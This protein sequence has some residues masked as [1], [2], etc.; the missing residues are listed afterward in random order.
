MYAMNTFG[1]FSVVLA[2]ALFLP[3]GEF[4]TLSHHPSHQYTKWLSSCYLPKCYNIRY[5]THRYT[6]RALRWRPTT[7][8]NRRQKEEGTGTQ[9]KRRWENREKAK[10]DRGESKKNA[11]N[12]SHGKS[13]CEIWIITSLHK[14]LLCQMENT[15]KNKRRGVEMKNTN[16]RK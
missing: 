3:T 7:K 15:K 10:T 12:W 14:Q 11:N 4:C 9:I 1:F 16:R 6:Q 13:E 5:T 2:V 8:R